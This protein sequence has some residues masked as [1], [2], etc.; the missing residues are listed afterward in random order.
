MYVTI[1]CTPSLCDFF[2]ENP[3]SYTLV[4]CMF[5][6]S[7]NVFFLSFH[8]LAFVV[9][10]IEKK[11]T[12]PRPIYTGFFATSVIFLRNGAKAR[13]GQNPEQFL[14]FPLCFQ[15]LLSI[16]LQYGNHLQS[17]AIWDGLKFVNV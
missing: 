7:Q 3:K 2:H 1:S 5:S 8:Q 12:R 6:F 10:S 17:P 4:T 14:L 16:L 13:P 15:A 11:L 9:F